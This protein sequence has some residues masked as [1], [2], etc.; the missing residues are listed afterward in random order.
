[1]EEYKTLEGNVAA[2]RATNNAAVAA[3]KRAAEMK[4]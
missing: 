1:M 2:M 4:D 3:A